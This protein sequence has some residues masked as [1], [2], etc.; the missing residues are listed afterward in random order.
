M[1]EKKEHVLSEDRGRYEHVYRDTMYFIDAMVED[2]DF[3]RGVF[4]MVKQ[5]AT[6][7]AIKKRKVNKLIDE[8]WINAIEESIVALDTVVRRPTKTI[9]EIE[10]VLPI[11]LSK[12]ITERSIRDLAQH[13]N[14][15]SKIEDDMVT[16]NRIL[17]IYRDETL[18]TYE[19]KFINTLVVRLY[20]FVNRRYQQIKDAGRDELN[21]AVSFDSVFESGRIK[22]K[23]TFGIEIIEDLSPDTP[24]EAAERE[25]DNVDYGSDLW[26]RV[27]YINMVVTEYMNSDFV[28]ALGKL[29]VRPP[30]MRTNAILKNKNVCR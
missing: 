25:A 20:T 6:E 26:K 19:N 23:F 11:E 16:P 21:S 30:I 17:N 9:K 18:E 7:I 27:E 5:G 4:A 12:N 2:Y 13:T 22:G 10:E 28:K 14:Y 15:I 3:Y 24:E 8:Q 29:Y 1:A